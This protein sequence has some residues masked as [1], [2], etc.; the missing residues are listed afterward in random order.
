MKWEDRKNERVENMTYQPVNESRHLWKYYVF[1]ILTLGIYCIW[2]EWTMIEDLN[3]ACGYVEDTQEYR[4]PNYLIRLLLSVV[5]CGIYIFFWYYK[6]GQRLRDAGRK[7]DLEIDD[8]GSTYLLWMLAGMLLFGIGPIIAFYIFI[9]NCNKICRCYNLRIREDRNSGNPLYTAKENSGQADATDFFHPHGVVTVD[10]ATESVSSSGLLRFTK[11]TMD[12][13]ELELKDG[14]SVLIGRDRT[15]CQM[16]LPD[17][18]ISHR[19]CMIRYSVADACYFVTDYSSLGTFMNGS[20][21]LTK[22][23]QTKCPVG[24]RLT[25]GSGSTE[26]Q[27]R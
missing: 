27:L 20:I 8:R 1:G 12:G 13:A 26:I 21:R 19:H 5:T 23:V 9:C 17:R 15:Q 10:P 7:Y 22:N 6:Q 18:D 24:T 14:E 2:F 25:L 11:G 3:T 4:S 16:I